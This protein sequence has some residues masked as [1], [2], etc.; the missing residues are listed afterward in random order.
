[1]HLARIEAAGNTQSRPRRRAVRSVA[2]ALRSASG[3]ALAAAI[4]VSVTGCGNTYRPVVSAINPVGPAAQPQK[5]A[6]VISTTGT[7]TANTTATFSS[8]ASSITVSSVTGI[9]SGQL[10]TGAGIAAGTTVSGPPSGTTV[11]LSLP[12]TSAESNTPVVFTNPT[13]GLVTFVDF[14]GD[15][16]LITAQIGVNPYYLILNSGGTTGY[17]LNSDHTLTTFDVDTQL[18]QSNILQT[19]L[20]PGAAPVSIFPEGTNTYV[21]DPGLNVVSQFTGQ[22]LN[23]QQQLSVNPAFTPIYVTGIAS[24]P[25]VYAISQRKGGGLGQVSTIET[26]SNTVDPNPIPVGQNPVY[27]VMTNDAKRA[28]ILNQGE[29][30]MSVINAQTNLLDTVP[31]GATNPIKVGTSP[32]WADFAPTRNEMVVANAG[33]GV[34]PGSL[35]IISTPLCSAAAQPNNPNCDPNNPVDAVGFGTVLATVPVG[36]NPV[37]VGVLQDGTRAYVV[38]SGNPKLPCAGAG[39]TGPSTGCSVS[40]INLTTNTV[41]ATIPLPLSPVNAGSPV[42]NGHP[43]YIAVTTGTP[44]GKVY[45]TSPESNFMTVIRT[46]TDAVDTTIPLQGNGVS[47]RVTQP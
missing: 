24:A 9:V 4:L 3:L 6:V 31:A 28:F 8:G 44:T 37:M 13:P 7:A 34:N 22:P 26:T 45:V 46:D 42:L 27:G 16:V 12:T 1:L 17:T 21:T 41:T 35:S 11:N 10:V 14:S 33:D 18:L 47:V 32:L 2:Q 5:F 40:V 29:G 30:T 20:L 38:N 19:T 39:V 43:N 23:L 25:R 15:T 36:V